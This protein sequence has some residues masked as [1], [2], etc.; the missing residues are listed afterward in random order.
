MMAAATPAAAA[1]YLLQLVA[2]FLL[3]TLAVYAMHRL[4]HWRHRWNLLFSLHRKHHSH[5]Y[6]REY[7]P[8]GWPHWK[9]WLLWLGDWQS[10]LDVLVSMTLPALLIAFWMPEVGIPILLFHYFYELFAS[11]HQLDHNPRI[12]G[13]LTHWFAWGDYHLH[14]HSHPLHNFG[15]MITLWDRV[16]GTAHDPKPGAAWRR[17][18]SQQSRNRGRLAVTPAIRPRD[19]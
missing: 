17:I 2:G 3:W 9:Q 12:S 19:S 13:R 15:L 4:A 11:E 10:S 6:L 1:S 16:F 5:P 8:P 7:V 14:H 18:Q